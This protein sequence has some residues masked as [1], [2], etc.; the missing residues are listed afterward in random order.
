[1]GASGALLKGRP[2]E[3]SVSDKELRRI[4]ADWRSTMLAVRRL[5]RDGS[6]RNPLVFVVASAAIEYLGKLYY[7]KSGAATFKKFVSR[8]LARTNKKYRT[9][10][11]RLGK[12]KVVRDLPTQ[13]YH[14]LRCGIVHSYSLVPDEMAR[15]NGG[16]DRAVVLVHRASK[17]PHLSHWFHEGQPTCVLVAEDLVGDLT[18]VL[19]ETFK[20]ALSNKAL[21]QRIRMWSRKHPPIQGGKVLTKAP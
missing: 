16:R 6:H 12:G 5:A 21:A 13:I 4:R 11:Y 15:S 7:A 8:R 9:F 10:R 1:M 2:W 20:E 3:R 18:T 17:V 14:V 19:E